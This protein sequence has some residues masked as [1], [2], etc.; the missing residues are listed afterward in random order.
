[1]TKTR[2]INIDETWLGMEDFT[3]MK[4]QAPGATNSIAKKLWAPRHS[5]I[6][7]LD[8]YGESFVALTQVNTDSDMMSLFLRDLVKQLN[9]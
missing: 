8:N 6:L 2:I 7:A 3:R 1:M 9:V 4:W 5:L